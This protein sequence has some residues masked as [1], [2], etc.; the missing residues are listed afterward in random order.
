MNSATATRAKVVAACVPLLVLGVPALAMAHTTSASATRASCRAGSPE[1]NLP[2]KNFLCPVKIPSSSGLGEPTIIADNGAGNKGVPRLF[3]TA[4]QAL[5][6]VQTSGGSPLFTSTDG[7]VKWSGPVRSQMCTGLSGGDTDLAVDAANNVYQTDLWLG[8]SC[9][10]VSEDHGTSF[11]AGDPFGQELQPGDDRPWLA[12]DSTIA[13]GGELFGTYDGLDALHIANTAPLVN[14]AAGLQAISDNVVIPESVVSAVTTPNPD[15]RYCV[16]PPGGVAV[17]NSHGTYR[18]RVYVSFSDAEG[19]RVAYD[20]PVANTTPTG[21]WTYTAIPDATSGSAF[22]DEWN[23][24][25]IHVDAKGN[26]YVMWAHALQ[27]SSSTDTAGAGGVQEYYAYST[28]GGQ[29]FSKPILLS[30][31]DGAKGLGGTTTFPTMSVLAPGVIDAAWY[32]TSAAGDPDKVPATAKWNL[33]YT[34]VT[35]ADTAHPTVATPQVAISDMHN[36]CIQTGG[37][38]SCSDRSLLDFFTLIDAKGIPNIIYTAGD[39]THGV[40]LYFTKLTASASPP[41][42][43]YA[44]YVDNVHLGAKGTY[45]GPFQPIPWQGSS[46]TRFVGCNDN[47]SGRLCTDKRPSTGKVCPTIHG[48]SPQMCYDAGALRFDNSGGS[49]VHISKVTVRIGTCTFNPWAG[50]P[51]SALVIPAHGR[52]ILTQTGGVGPNVACHFGPDPGVPFNFDTSDTSPHGS[53]KPT[54][55]IPVISVTT[56]TGTTTYRD[57]RQILDHGGVDP[58]CR[59]KN[60]NEYTNW[61][62]LS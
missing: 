45:S 11:T 46:G 25:P 35:N 19:T 4:P 50:E 43:A 42:K 21:T 33:Y 28:D 8:N 38:A 13:N 29:K 60:A 48:S 56:S 2:G 36:G 47:V 30:T 39:V 58:S 17:D 51:A 31:E 54:G 9:I 40:N 12:Y 57:T 1:K 59:A 32:G 3:V 24:D 26:V 55:Y 61:S 14:P 20:T 52:L 37:G 22:Q 16:C 34:R 27:F 10:S 15:I 49:P 6:N 53:C 5:G 18:G 62:P 23:F 41:V 44:G 7:G